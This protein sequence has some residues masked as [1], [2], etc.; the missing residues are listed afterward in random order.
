MLKLLVLLFETFDQRHQVLD[1]Y[2]ER[3]IIAV[4]SCLKRGVDLA[5]RV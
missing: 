5:L 2:I 1:V 3:I 4:V